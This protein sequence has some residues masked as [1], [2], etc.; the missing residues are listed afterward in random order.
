[1]HVIVVQFSD[2]IEQGKPATEHEVADEPDESK[3]VPLIVS[4]LPPVVISEDQ[5][6][7]VIDGAS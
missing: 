1:M 6:T 5:V 2:A 3:P 4:M 7:E